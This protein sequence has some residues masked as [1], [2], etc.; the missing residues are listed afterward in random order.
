MNEM[1][2]CAKCYIKEEMPT[3]YVKIKNEVPPASNRMTNVKCRLCTEYA[4]IR[5]RYER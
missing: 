4:V 5:E 1:A 3:L 2:L